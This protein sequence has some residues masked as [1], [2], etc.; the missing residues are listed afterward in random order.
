MTPQQ[1]RNRTIIERYGSHK[2]MLASRDVR[3][4]ILG[5]YNGGIKKTKKGFATWEPQKLR[6]YTSK[7]KRDS[8]GRFVAET[9]EGTSDSAKGT[10]EQ[11][12]R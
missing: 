10:E 11:A 5:G 2:K 1:K 12:D 4:L 8:Q 9:E 3:D 7:R 6:R